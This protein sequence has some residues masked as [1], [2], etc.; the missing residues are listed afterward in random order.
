MLQDLLAG[1]KLELAA[2]TGAAIELDEL[3]GVAMPATRRLDAMTRL[4]A[5]ALG[6]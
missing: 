4:L 3:A 5:T 6:I 1:K 2:L